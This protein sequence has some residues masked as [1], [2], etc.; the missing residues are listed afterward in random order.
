MN[1]NIDPTTSIHPISY[2]TTSTPLNSVFT[3]VDYVP[4]ELTYNGTVLLNRDDM[5]RALGIVNYNQY[6]IQ[7][8]AGSTV[9]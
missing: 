1:V 4:S 9:S 5:C 3:D 2:V 7:D 6:G 8:R